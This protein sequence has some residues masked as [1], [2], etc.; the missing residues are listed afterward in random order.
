VKEGSSPKLALCWGTV[1]GADFDGLLAAARSAGVAAVMMSPALYFKARAAGRSEADLNRAV[2]AFGVEVAVVDALVSPLPG[3][4][5]P[6]TVPEAVRPVFA[7][8]EA[9]CLRM[10]EVLGAAVVNVAH[11]MGGMVS[12]AEMAAALAGIARRAHTRGLQ[13]SVEF[14]PNSGTIPDLAAAS[15]IVAAAGESNLGVMLDTWHLFRSAGEP[16]D[17]AAAPAGLFF[18]VQVADAP[19][20]AKGRPP[21][22]MQDRLM[23]GEGAIPISAILAE[24]LRRSPQAVVGV[25]VI[26]ATMAALA[27]DAAAVA[28][29]AA[30]RRFLPTIA[31]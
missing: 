20:D 28:A 27:P 12:E 10:A 21:L 9:D 26:S 23:P 22:P 15:R 14:M 3:L 2:Q 4:P 18:G 24:V 8:R 1:R 19:A 25:E 7:F 16:A 29:V 30:M 13:V 6:A 31:G 17:I 11:V 5:D